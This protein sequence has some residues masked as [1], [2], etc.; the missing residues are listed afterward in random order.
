[1]DAPQTTYGSLLVLQYLYDNL[2][3]FRFLSG[4]FFS[5]SCLSCRFSSHVPCLSPL[6]FF[7]P[8]YTPLLL[9]PMFRFP[10][11][12][13]SPDGLSLP[14]L[15]EDNR[16]LP[17]M[18]PTRDAQPPSACC[19]DVPAS[20]CFS[21]AQCRSPFRTCLGSRCDRSPDVFPPFCNRLPSVP[22]PTPAS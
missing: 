5:D 13:F 4:R 20:L 19:S 16:W 3:S 14:L 1:M 7:F 12:F 10:E 18:P 22:L 17:C 15:S 2:L 8:S 21:M 11:I 6:V 9:L